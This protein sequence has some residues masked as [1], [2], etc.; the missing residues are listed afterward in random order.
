MIGTFDNVHVPQTLL[1][2]LEFFRMDMLE[3][4]V[5]ADLVEID[6]PQVAHD[7]DCFTYV[8]PLYN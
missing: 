4:S 3:N 1:P 2:P 8:N 6:Y 7:G 5:L